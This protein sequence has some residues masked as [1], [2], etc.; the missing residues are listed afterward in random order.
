MTLEQHWSTFVYI[1]L[2]FLESL[3]KGNGYITRL[4]PEKVEDQQ[5]LHKLD[6]VFSR[7][8]FDIARKI[9]ID[10]VSDSVCSF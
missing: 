2:A 5:R 6:P 1:E 10:F 8:L 4:P 9:P 7:R 3:F